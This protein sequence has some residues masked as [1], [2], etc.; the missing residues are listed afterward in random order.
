L[1]TLHL[2]C[3][4]QLRQLVQLGG[5]EVLIGVIAFVLELALAER[6][7]HD[8]IQRCWIFCVL[9][10]S[11][12]GAAWCITVTAWPMGALAPANVARRSEVFTKTMAD[13]GSPS[14]STALL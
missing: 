9:V 2:S 6:D 14:P 3:L 4:A 10:S 12:A 1:R 13:C 5:R 8:V 11:R 7:A